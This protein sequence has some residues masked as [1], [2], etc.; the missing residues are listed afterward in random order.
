MLVVGDQVPPPLVDTSYVTVAPASTPATARSN[1][2]SLLTKSLENVPLSV[3][4]LS[5]SVPAG[6]GV[7]ST[8]NTSAGLAGLSVPRPLVKV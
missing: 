2:L 5:V 7:A 4:L 3:K 1:V 6:G 8:V